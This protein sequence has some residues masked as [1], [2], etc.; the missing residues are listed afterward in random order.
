MSRT[1]WACSILVL[2]VAT[3][4]VAAGPGQELQEVADEN[5]SL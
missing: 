4:G 1:H 2:S 5:R 3:F